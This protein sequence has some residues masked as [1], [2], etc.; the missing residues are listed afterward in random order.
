MVVLYKMEIDKDDVE[1]CFITVEKE[2]ISLKQ[3][4]LC[5]CKLELFIYLWLSFLLV[6]S[7]EVIQGFFESKENKANP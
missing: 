5:G 4:S 2:T 6:R 3:L 7:Y 1:W